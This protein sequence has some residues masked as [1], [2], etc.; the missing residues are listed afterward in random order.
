MMSVESFE[1]NYGKYYDL[2]Y[3]DK[4]Y[5][6]EAAY[7]K[8][9]INEYAPNA[10]FILEYGCGTG[11]HGIILNQ[12]GFSVFGLDNSAYQIAVA[13]SKGLSCEVA[14][15]VNFELNKK[16]DVCIALFHVIGY[17]NS[18]DQVIK[19][20]NNANRHLVA[21]GIFI[22]DTWFTPAVLTSIPSFREKRVEDAEVEIVRTTKPSMDFASNLVR[23]HFEFTIT[24]KSDGYTNSFEEIHRMRH[25]GIPEVDLIAKQTGFEVKRVEEFGSLRP[26]S[27]KSWGVNFVLQK[28]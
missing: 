2:L 23:I 3:S 15:I 10:V 25:F 22:F 14:D 17:M 27:D 16:F 5:G 7:I 24:R 18:N 12:F 6:I 4:D 26:P 13:K 28:L 21:G 19:A 9:L 8:S 11:N 20:F 1:G